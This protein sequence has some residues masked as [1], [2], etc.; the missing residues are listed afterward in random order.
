MSELHQA[1]MKSDL[2]AVKLLLCQKDIEVNSR[3]LSGALAF[4]PLHVAARRGDVKV[5]RCLL[6]DP[7]VDIEARDNTR[8]T[9]LRHAMGTGQLASAS[10]SRPNGLLLQ[11]LLLLLL[12]AC[13]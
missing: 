4:T 9:A 13:M 12:L 6:L 5:L 10:K 8:C 11:L 3:D 7:R 1:V 2:D